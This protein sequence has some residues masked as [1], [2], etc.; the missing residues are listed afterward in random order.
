M[1]LISGLI[2][3]FAL[4]ASTVA[5]SQGVDTLP[6]YGVSPTRA[7][8]VSD[9]D[10]VDTGSGNLMFNIPLYSLPQKGAL[11]MSFSIR[12]NS[13]GWTEVATCDDP[14]W[15]CIYSYQ[16]SGVSSGSITSPITP[17]VAFDQ[18]LST[19]D[20]SQMVFEATPQACSG[21]SWCSSTYNP[22][23]SVLDASGA[24][25]PM[26]YDTN[27]YTRLRAADGS[28]YMYYT[29]TPLYGS[30]MG[31]TYYD[32]GIIYEPNGIAH[33]QTQVTSID[34][35]NTG[36]K[37]YSGNEQ[38]IDPNGNAILHS[39][40]SS[41]G[42]YTSSFTDTLHP[43]FL[44]P[45][46]GNYASS[47]AGCPTM[48]RST[49]QVLVGSFQWNVPSSQD[50]G[51]SATYLLCY[52]K[53][54]VRTNFF[55]EVCGGPCGLDWTYNHDTDADLIVLDSVVLPD[56]T[57]Y[58]GFIY[59]SAD[60]NNQNSVAYAEVQQVRLPTGG[61]I[62]YSYK[63]QTGCSASLA[64]WSG[65]T[66][67]I[68][69]RTTDDNAG[70][71]ATWT[72]D[73]G[74]APTSQDSYKSVI[75]NPPVSSPTTPTVQ[76]VNDT[77]VTYSP[78]VTYSAIFA[79]CTYVQTKVDTYQGSQSSGTLIESDGTEYQHSVGPYSLDGG[80]QT[81]VAILPKTRSKFIPNAGT[82]TTT[83]QYGTS[84]YATMPEWYSNPDLSIAWGFSSIVPIP[85]GTVTSQTETD[86]DGQTV[87]RSQ[88]ID[89]YW[90]THNA[91]YLAN[92]IDIPNDVIVSGP[93]NS[94][95]TYYS[96]DDAN[97]SPAGVHGNQTTVSKWLNTA[98][99]NVSTHVVYTSAGMPT[100]VIDARGN[101]KVINYDSTG[102]FVQ[103]VSEG[104]LTDQYSIDPNTGSVMSHTD[105]NNVVTKY[106]YADSLSRVTQIQHAVGTP[107]ESWTTFAYPDHNTVSTKQDQNTRGDRLLQSLQVTDGLGR[108]VH[109]TAPSNAVTDISYDGLGR[110]STMSNPYLTSTDPTYGVTTMLY[111]A[112]GRRTTELH[113]DNSSKS[114]SYSG[115]TATSY[116]E[117]LNSWKR[118]SDALGRMTNVV[119]SGNL[120]TGYSYD[121]LGNLRAVNQFGNGSTDTPRT[122]RF[123]YDSLSRLIQSYNPETGWICYGTTPGNVAPNGS[124]CTPGYDAN[125]NLLKKTDANGIVLT[126]T[127]DSLNR[128]LTVDASGYG[129]IHDSFAYDEVFGNGIGRL[130]SNGTY[131]AGTQFTYDP[132]GRVIHTQT[133]V[134]PHIPR[135]P[136]F[137]ATYDLAGNLITLK[138][139]DGLQ[140]TQSWDAAGHLQ[141]VSSP[142]TAQSPAFDYISGP[143]Q[144][145]GIQY[146][147]SGAEQAFV[148]GSGI[149]QSSTYNNRLQLC[150]IQ[151]GTVL[152]GSSQMLNLL[153]KQY[154]HAKTPETLCGN[155]N[156]NNGNIWSIADV[157]RPGLTQTFAYDSLNRLTSAL[158][159]DS[160][161]SQAYSLDSF[162]NMKPQ[163]TLSTALNYSIDPQTN[164]LQRN[165]TD[166]QYDA[167]GNLTGIA[168]ALSNH[169]Y[170]PNARGQLVT[171]DGGNTAKYYYYADGLRA[172]KVT[173]SGWTDYENFNGQQTAELSS[174]GTWTDYV[175]ANGRKIAKVSSLVHNVLHHSGICG[176]CSSGSSNFT[177][178]GLA[179][180][181]SGYQLRSGDQLIFQQKQINARAGLYMY[182]SDGTNSM[183]YLL[184]QN[185]DWINSSSVADGNW[186][187]RVVDLT[188][189]TGKSISNNLGASVEANTP[190]GIQ[191]DSYITDVALV[192][193]D[194]TVQPLFTGQSVTASPWNSSAGSSF[195]L[196]TSAQPASVATRYYL[197]DHLGTAQLEFSGGGWPVWKGE[198]TPFGQEID[199]QFTS[200][201][202]KFTGKERDAESGLDYFGARYYSSSMGR[203]MSPDWS[204]SP[205]P[206]PYADLNSPQ[207]LN[208]YGYVGNNPLRGRDL[209]GH[210]DC[211]GD[212]VNGVGCQAI[213]EWNRIHGIAERTLNRV[214]QAVTGTAEFSIRDSGDR[215][216]LAQKILGGANTA[217]SIIVPAIVTDGL[218]L[219]AE[220]GMA[221]GS[222]AETSVGSELSTAAGRAVG[223]VGEGQGA[224][225]G[226]RVH[227]AFEA[228][229]NALGNPNLSTEVSYLNGKVVSRGTPGSVRIDVIEGPRANPTA[230]YDLKTGQAGLSPSRVQQIQSHLPGGNKVPVHEVRP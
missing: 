194:G 30:G 178:T 164:R 158:S 46:L 141:K 210:I 42:I 153:N 215:A 61:T 97:G 140:V 43:Q 138:Y 199:T 41:P 189:W 119:E 2:C 88:Q 8:H 223:A 84:F 31:A 222:L 142:A 109:S 193:A 130:T 228:E 160:S 67:V 128:L 126:S 74:V 162:G 118:T 212:N 174:D 24:R 86:Y 214:G 102:A 63:T 129:Y 1:K 52:A 44:D 57:S 150:Q 20:D 132:M 7:Y 58:W 96:Y 95:T 9:F 167:A 127:Y 144:S 77:V 190:S 219:E 47:T 59:S 157:Q 29:T 114:W 203:W 159:A 184:D 34:Y 149:V 65:N 39:F 145:G 155:A 146:T 201:N 110:V 198:F 152:P 50:G 76:E 188:N 112:L 185:G 200:N 45:T 13:M 26:A 10:S 62:S 202:Y 177:L 89:P 72:Y 137:D 213:A 38:I 217:A 169:T 221:L 205:V 168:D 224:V 173:P 3:A 117:S 106:Q 49:F 19:I 182:A 154:F 181:I 136:G 121:A 206:I 27:D 80:R 90:V 227:S 220:E 66:R 98:N 78:V 179:S 17:T 108:I 196:D 175:Y 183:G 107:Q 81:A 170:Y 192:S 147:P 116:D 208:L 125:G 187:T 54:H 123:S 22:T 204:E 191:W 71:T 18:E 216:A 230:A 36:A 211:S 48:A 60:P 91:Y 37:Y 40:T 209:D 85:F 75:H 101:S 15:P 180:N 64:G 161:Y 120:Q 197:S 104:P 82:A 135:T 100:T 195:A 122:R 207:S 83:Y 105:P 11:S 53:I 93:G 131:A 133:A 70:H 163:N 113:P 79:P 69:S 176:V 171:I 35:S 172:A 139:P 166:F 92:F 87:L 151:V 51:G 21:Q 32:P 134:P 186:H 124:N 111:D 94:S 33:K 115:N 148:L 229:V 5:F 165:A 23:F 218:S 25:H 55:P 68:S 156:G 56:K 14:D 103:S 143:S 28:N 4:L 73:I 12:S 99:S 225:Y 226:T 6:Q 16:W